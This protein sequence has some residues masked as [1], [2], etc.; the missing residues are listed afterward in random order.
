[1]RESG[2]LEE[3]RREVREVQAYK[4]WEHWDAM[5]EG[6]YRVVDNPD[7]SLHGYELRLT[8]LRQRVSLAETS[9]WT[10]RGVK[11]ERI[12]RKPPGYAEQRD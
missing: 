1:M 7:S 4:R 3:V 5:R 10:F 9:S 2:M 11:E 6:V 8:V 12:E